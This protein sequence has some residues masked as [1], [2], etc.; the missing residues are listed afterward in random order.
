MS[1]VEVRMSIIE[2][3]D[4]IHDLLFLKKVEEI[5]NGKV[6]EETYVLSD[7][8]KSRVLSGREQRKNGTLTSS[9]DFHKEIEEWLRSK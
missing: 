9:E 2:K 3:L 4:A 1:E 6:L 8:Q 5:V 7:T